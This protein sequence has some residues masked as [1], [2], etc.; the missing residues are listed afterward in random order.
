L[1]NFVAVQKVVMFRTYVNVE[2]CVKVPI[3]ESLKSLQFV[4][5]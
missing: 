1:L 3:S 4:E 5:E 2:K